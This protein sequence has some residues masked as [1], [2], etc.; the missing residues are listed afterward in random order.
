MLLNRSLE[1]YPNWEEGR[2]LRDQLKSEALSHNTRGQKVHFGYI[3]RLT[4]EREAAM[5]PCALPPNVKNG[6]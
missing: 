6:L 3:F 5:A 1:E 2:R 4:H